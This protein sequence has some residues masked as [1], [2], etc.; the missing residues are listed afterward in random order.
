MR[1]QYPELDHISDEKL[2]AHGNAFCTIRGAALGDQFKKSMGEL[3]T[4]PKQ[5]SGLLGAAHGLCRS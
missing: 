4:T 5:T 2:L 3:G 1:K